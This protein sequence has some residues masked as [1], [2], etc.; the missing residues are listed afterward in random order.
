MKF[1]KTAQGKSSGG[2]FMLEYEKKIM[3]TANE[4]HTLAMSNRCKNIPKQLQTNYYFD[5]DNFT[6]NKKGITCRIR[7]KNGKYT[8]C[9]KNHN[10]NHCDCSMESNLPEDVKFDPHFFKT[11]GLQCQGELV[12]ERIVIYKDSDCEI[13]LDRNVYLGHTDFELEVEY[14]QDSEQKAQKLIKSIAEYLTV[15][16]HF[17]ESESFLK[18]IGQ[19]K[20]K[21]QRFFEYLSA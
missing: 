5:D 14:C 20:S 15:T 21:S 9:V 7:H 4:Y 12:T 19:G 8:A 13:M 6:M 11:L 10:T 3:L 16:R 2:E 17:E 18:R 1:L